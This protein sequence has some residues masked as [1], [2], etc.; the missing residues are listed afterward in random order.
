MYNPAFDPRIKFGIPAAAGVA[1][2]AGTAMNDGT[3]L[4]AVGAGLGGA[5]G[6]A[7]GL[8]AARGLAGKY[9]PQLIQRA[10][11][12]VS[13]AGNR[14]GDYARTLPEGSRVRKAAADAMADGISLVDNRVFGVPGERNAMIPFP[15]QGVQ[16]NV[17]KGLSAVLVPAAGA[18]AALGGVAAGQAVGAVG[19]MMGIDPEMPGSSNTVNSRLSMQSA[20]LPMY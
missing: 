18:S 4:E 12:A 15:T 1:L 16:Q 10:G 14:V 13:G 2:A 19:Q 9:N 7:A 17:Q 11:K 6:G 3:P 5:A 8:L 20:M